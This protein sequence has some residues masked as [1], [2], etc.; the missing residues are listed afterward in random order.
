MKF[1]KHIPA[2]LL[3]ALFL[4]GGVSYLANLAPQPPMTGDP[5][6]FMKLFGGS[7][8]M[9]TI[10]VLEVICAI[11]IFIPK[12]RALGLILLAPIVVNILLFELHLAKQPGIG[13][14]LV[15]VNALAIYLVK[16][17]YASILAD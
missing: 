4:F 6:T 7:G 13:V 15:L 14:A 8:Y 17:K 9:T 16:D 11:L 1:V 3:G 12:T 10:K 5:E 2:F